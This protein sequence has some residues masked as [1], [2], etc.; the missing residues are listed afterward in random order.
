[1]RRRYKREVFSDRIYVVKELI[2]SAG[3][4]A[5]VIVG[6]P[7]ESAEDFSDTYDFINLLPVS[8]LHVFTFSERPGT[9]ASTLPGKVSFEEKVSRSKKLI[10]LSKQKHN[11]FLTQNIG[12][13][14]SVLF[15]HAKSAG[16]IGG[17][18]A[19]YI[20]VEHPWF[21]ALAGEIKKVRLTGISDN[22][23]MKIE[24]ID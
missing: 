5:D 9:V 22:G 8:Y 1:M 2:P 19:N 3:I 23:K 12:C 15:E 7:G 10:S 20:R 4:G 14:A 21:P 11:A 18:T 6:F 13:N 16:M 17:Y 24:L